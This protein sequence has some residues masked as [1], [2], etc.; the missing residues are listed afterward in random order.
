MI[1]G[2]NIYRDVCVQLHSNTVDLFEFRVDIHSH[3]ASLT[4]RDP[5]RER[6]DEVLNLNALTCFVISEWTHQ[7]II[8]L[9]RNKTVPIYVLVIFF[10][11]TD[12]CLDRGDVRSPEALFAELIVKTRA[13][14]FLMIK[15]IRLSNS[16]I[17][18]ERLPVLIFEFCFETLRQIV[19]LTV[20]ESSEKHLPTSDTVISAQ[21]LE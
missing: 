18:L 17:H 14:L 4:E 2:Q 11:T 9:K 10:F 15:G 3:A 12:I 6:L 19:S 7:W 5:G 20:C 1:F 8:I 16:N 21:H 13:P